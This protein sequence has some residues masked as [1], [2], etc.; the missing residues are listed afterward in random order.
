V[1]NSR[2][3]FRYF[4]WMV[5]N[6]P[7]LLAQVVTRHVP[8]FYQVL[9]RVARSGHSDEPLRQAHEAELD[10]MVLEHPLGEKLR[11]IDAL[12]EAHGSA[13]ILASEISRRALKAAGYF[14][15]GGFLVAGLWLSALHALSTTQ[16]GFGWKAVLFL[17][18]SFLFV[19]SSAAA[20][21]YLLLRPAS[22][23][24]DLAPHRAAQRIAGLVGVPLVAFG[25]THD[26]VIARI[27]AGRERGWYFN[28]GTWIAV[29][30]YDA[31]LPRERVQYT[32]LR[33][34]GMTGELLQWS[35]GRGDAV[36]VVLLED[37][38]GEEPA[39]PSEARA[40]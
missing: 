20:L 35:P 12:K 19:V 16:A 39:R 6:R 25:H 8:F 31:L 22:R 24:Y 29:F 15:F 18:L 40:S 2:S 14:L 13:S 5:L 10:R 30:A 3:N 33:I 1:P 7:R 23:E 27:D 4:R 17:A 36:P 28:T 38:S 11:Q 26:E 32:F 37:D 9:R 34:R 21:T